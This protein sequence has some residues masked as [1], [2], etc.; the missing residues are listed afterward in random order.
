MGQSA[1][2]F[3]RVHPGPIFSKALQHYNLEIFARV[4]CSLVPSSKYTT[5]TSWV[6]L[7]LEAADSSTHLS[8]TAAGI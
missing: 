6:T 7:K 1:S 5:D 8:E 3:N 4:R 2:S